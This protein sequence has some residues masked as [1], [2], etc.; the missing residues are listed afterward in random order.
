MNSTSVGSIAIKPYSIPLLAA[1]IALIAT[2]SLWPILKEIPTLFFLASVIVSGCYRGLKAGVSTAILSLICLHS[3][4]GYPLFHPWEQWEDLV[5]LALFALV[6]LLTSSLNEA[7]RKLKEIANQKE[8]L[9]LI[10]DAIPTP[11]Y[12]LDAAR[13][14]QFKNKAYQEWFGDFPN[15]IKEQ[16]ITEILEPT[17]ARENSTDLEAAF[18]GQKITTKKLISLPGSSQRYIQTSYV[19][20]FSK[21]GDVQGCVVAINDLT[22]RQ[23]D[24]EALEQERDLIE[25]ILRTA[26]SLI[27]VLDRQGKIVRFNQAC[28]EI[29]GYSFAEVKDKFV[30]DLFIPTPEIEAIQQVFQALV[31]GDFPNQYEGYWVVRDGTRRLIVWSN[32]AIL[33]QDERVE[34]I[35]GTGLDIT[36]RKAAEIALAV[37]YNQLESRVRGRTAALIT[38]NNAL[39]VEIAERQKIEAALRESE[40]KFRSLSACSPIGIFTT[41][42]EGYCTY[43]NPRFQAICGLTLAES[44]GR[45]W[46]SFIH[47]EDRDRIFAEWCQSTHEGREYF[48][49]FR[50]QS[51]D[52]TW[53]WVQ[54]RSAPMFCT[55]GQLI[56]HVGTVEDITKRRQIEAAL[57]QSE[58]QF[59]TVVE[60]IPDVIIRCDRDGRYLYVNP[61]VERIQKA[62]AAEIVGKTSS[63]LG[64]PSELCQLWDESLAQVFTTG[65]EQT[66]QYQ[67]SH[68]EGLITF[69]SRIV[70]EFNQEG[71]IQNAL[72]VARDITELKQAEAQAALLVAERAARE[73][74]EVQQQRSAFL[75][76][77]SKVLTA[78]LDSETALQNVAELAVPAVA[79]GCLI[80]RLEADGTIR[81]IAITHL[82]PSAVALFEQLEQ[83]YPTSPN[84]SQGYPFVLRTGEPYLLLETSDEML[85]AYAQD[86]THL[87]MLRQLKLGSYLCVPLIAGGRVLGALTFITT[88]SGRRYHREDLTVF[89]DLAS[90]CALTVENLRLYR[91]AQAALSQ[92]AES[93]ALIDALLSA[94]PLGLCFLDRELRFIRINQVLADLNGLPIAA[95]LG[96]TVREL[97]PETADNFEFLI[98]QVLETGETLLNVELSG[99]PVGKPGY[100]GHWLGNYYPVKGAGGEVLGV[101][102][103]LTEVTE[104][105][106]AEVA[107]RDSERRF[108]SVVESNMIGIGFWEGEGRITDA[109]EAL[110]QMVG[111]SRED[112]NSSQLCW[113]DFTPAD[114][115][116]LDRQ[117]IAQIQATGCCTPYEKECLRS[118]GSRFPVLAGGGHLEGCQDRGAFF[119]L[120]ISGRKQA[121][122]AERQ[123]NRKL[124]NILES[125]TD[126]F[127]ALNRDWEFTYINNRCETLMQRRQEELLGAC[128]WEVFPQLVDTVFYEQYHRALYQQIPVHLEAAGFI[129]P[130]RWYEVH[131]YPWSDGLAVYI[132]DISKRKHTELALRESEARVQRQ[133]AELDHLYNTTPVGLCFVDTNLH[134]IRLNQYLAEIN[135][136]AIA[137]HLGQRVGAVLPDMADTL[138]PLYR[139]VIETQ[140]P[141]LNLEIQGMTAQ[142]PGIIRDWLVN[143]YPVFDAQGVFLG[144][145]SVVQ[146]ITDRKRTERT[147][148]ESEAIFRRLFEA[149]IFGVA[150]GDF[151]GRITYANDALLKMVG[152]SQEEMLRGEL[153][154]DTMTAPEYASLDLR[155]NEELRTTGV[156]T[157]FEKAYIRKDGSRVPVLMG[158]ALLNEVDRNQETMICFYIDLTEI[159][160]VEAELKQ[161]QEWLQL[162]QR[163]SKIGTF[164]WNIQ[165]QKSIWTQELEALYGLAPG[166]YGGK[167]ENWLERVHPDD[168]TLADQTIKAGVATGGEIDAE[169]RICRPDGTIRWVACRAAV[170]A[171]EQGLPLR[172]VGVNMDI[173]DVYNELRLRKQAEEALSETNQ[174]LEALIQACPLGI[175]VFSAEDGTVKLWNPAA[176]RIFGWSESEVL[177]AIMPAIPE[178]KREE[179]AANLEQIRAGKA[180]AA[181]ETC[182]QRKD[183]SAIEISLWATP[184]GDAKGNIDCMSLVADITDRRRAEVERAQLLAREQTARAEAET[185]NRMKDE[186]LATLSHELRTPLN[187]I[188]GWSQLLCT[189]KFNEATT[190]RALETIERQARV[191]AQLVDDLLDVSRIIQGKLCLNVGWFDLAQVIEAAMNSVGLMAQTKSIELECDLDPNVGLMWGDAERLQQVVWNLLSN[192]IK[193][194]SPA[195]RVD[196]KLSAVRGLQLGDRQSQAA[197]ANYAEIQVSDSGKGIAPEF[198][199][200]VFE[201][202]RQGDGSITRTYGGL[203]LGLAIV[204]HLVE[205]H[206]GT[207]Y[208]ESAGEGQGATFTVRLPLRKTRSGGEQPAAETPVEAAIDASF[209]GITTELKGLQVLV[210][211]DDA[212]TRDFLITLLEEEGATAIAVA[213]AA[214]AMVALAHWRPDVLVSDIGMPGEDGYSLIGKIRA[215]E[216]EFCDRLPAVALTAYARE[217]DREQ[218]LKAGY[219][220]HLAK[221][222]DPDELLATL[223]RLRDRIADR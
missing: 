79:D 93:F 42:T 133:L 189:R 87:E 19:P 123:A 72:V 215:L 58:Q 39:Q 10:A 175:M 61:V 12:Y 128:I 63:E 37:S 194:T 56:G 25:A 84:A 68:P 8:E 32:T 89:A 218:A 91:E 196:V 3:L 198:I 204:R 7:E 35:I 187:A 214:E 174:T 160:E 119:V 135:G 54:L 76:E 171:D 132:Q 29:T 200:F 182:R 82:D 44:L 15:L 146:E 161:N 98:R 141:L 107:L 163:V 21:Q 188:L 136:K 211:D 88:Q 114:Y 184:V 124:V 185:M 113:A 11:I 118:D 183:G 193:F 115:T 217:Q 176:E 165:T 157:P 16:S 179:F 24:Q 83:C 14:Y 105:K 222:V 51:Q 147:L 66:I 86:A 173:S 209:K 104:A 149:N 90:R 47:P 103:I 142:Q 101:G 69:Q 49:E 168:R 71:Q 23:K 169:F 67:I 43:S 26:Q 6:A 17:I 1:G 99:E 52:G 53:R 150:I 178:D 205:L 22:E 81:R 97:L 129:P 131:A 108:R 77:V 50:F 199:P 31:N 191:Q 134:F 4:F 140:Q 60:N 116:A 213:S 151:Q 164:E 216:S 156:A 111:Y 195:G 172:V 78:S 207:V 126:A 38:T 137:E 80:H 85:V 177:G 197:V 206:G 45:G 96:Q 154:W 30:W 201:R 145:S 102:L 223:V 20:H 74:A 180:L 59:K 13:R 203:G 100:F 46:V 212:D 48:S 94:A 192:A 143:H 55:V 167:Y 120:D 208:A 148:R 36:D 210:V 57:S 95:H 28:E 153:W 125:I 144:V 62:S 73:K 158:A 221:P 138:E 41:D 18:S 130:D 170:L 2:L 219:D 112:L 106:R 166:S 202:F 159:K 40:E 33:G 75:A 220:R 27:I 109:N 5:R 190:A 65:V 117:A 152:Y 70:P 92:T 64:I 181:V 122:A 9:R 186:F 121:E 34:Y 155:V 162:A 139:Q 110:L 127:F